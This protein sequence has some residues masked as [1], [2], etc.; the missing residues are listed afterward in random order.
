M[1]ETTGPWEVGEFTLT[2]EGTLTGPAAYM[3][4]E[5]YATTMRQIQAGTE[6][7]FKYGAA[8]ASPSAE[9]ALLVAVQTS[10][11]GWKGA[12]QLL[13]ALERSA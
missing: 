6:P 2:A 11:A 3:E 5:E 7:V 12:R 10:Y 9:I 4:S 13:G 1:T 8:G